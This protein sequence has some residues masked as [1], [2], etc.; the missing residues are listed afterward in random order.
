MTLIQI[1]NEI[2]QI[3]DGQALVKQ[4]EI[5]D[6][7][8]ILNKEGSIKYGVVT[9]DITGVERDENFIK[10]DCYIYYADRT[11]QDNSN[12]KNIQSDAVNVILSIVNEIEDILDVEIEDGWQISTF[13][14]KFFDYC[15]GAWVN[16]K[17]IDESP[18]G[19]CSIENY[20]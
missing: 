4:A 7:Y 9:V 2:K 11:T 16:L 8:Q 3:A 12:E 19:Y 1:L 6:V 13:S 5:G 10:W 14:Q 18:V 15:A 20:E 17:I